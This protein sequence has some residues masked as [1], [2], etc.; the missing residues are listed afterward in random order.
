MLMDE[1]KFVKIKRGLRKIFYKILTVRNGR[2]ELLI[3][4]D[5]FISLRLFLG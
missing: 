3:K 4:S 1:F 5:V 2:C